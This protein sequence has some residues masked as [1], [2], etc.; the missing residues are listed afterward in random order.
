MKTTIFAILTALA[1]LAA[2]AADIKPIDVKP[3]LWETTVKNDVTGMPAMQMPQ[4]PEETLNRMPPE[5]R[6]RVE[7]MM[8]GRGAGGTNTS[9]SCITQEMVNQGLNFQNDKSCTYK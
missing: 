5:Q 6:A 3:G 8:K 4:I 9:K 7:A 2:S 1:P